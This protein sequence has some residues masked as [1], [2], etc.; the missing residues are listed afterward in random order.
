MMDAIRNILQRLRMMIG[1]GRVT[2]LDDS[3][4]AQV[5]QVQFGP[6]ETNDCLRLAEFG[7]A[8]NP[9]VGSDVA[10]VFISG[11]RSN[12]IVVA[13]GNQTL[14][15]KNLLP[16]ESALYDALG[17]Y[18]YLTK[19]GIVIEAKGQPVTINNASTVTVNAA[20]EVVLNTPTLQVN[21]NIVASGDISDQNGAKGTLQHIRDDY[22]VHTHPDAQGG[23][24]GV[25]S[26]TL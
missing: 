5:V 25:P 9:P 2:F 1:R 4:P 14:R 20:T 10:A 22:D 11:D 12:G 8:S 6:L 15:L 16:G 19:N 3:G 7:F 13:T 17:K 24:T 23:N 18:I 21:G 26:N